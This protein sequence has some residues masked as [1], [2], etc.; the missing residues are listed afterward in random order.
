MAWDENI[1]KTLKYC[2]TN[3]FIGQNVIFTNPDEVYLGNNVR[4]DP[5]TLITTQLTA[6]DYIQICSHAVLGGGKRNHI[7]LNGWNFIGYGSQLFCGSEDYSGNYGPVNEFWGN[8]KVHHAPIVFEPYAGVA[9]QCIVMPGCTLPTGTCIGAKSFVYKTHTLN[10][11]TLEKIPK[12]NEWSVYSGNPLVFRAKRNKET[13][14]NLSQSPDF[15]KTY[16]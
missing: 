5:F 3:V 2:G 7:T 4:I 11:D 12:L 10:T 6:G 8:N 14:L 13:V 1:K 16:Q 9:S 15:I